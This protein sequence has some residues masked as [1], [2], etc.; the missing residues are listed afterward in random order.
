MKTTESGIPYTLQ[1]WV[2]ASTKDL[3]GML[4]ATNAV[5]S[6]GTSAR[7]AATATGARILSEDK[8]YI[9]RMTVPAPSLGAST[10]GAPDRAGAV[11]SEAAPVAELDEID[12]EDARDQIAASYAADPVLPLCARCGESV[13]VLEQWVDGIEKIWHERCYGELPASLRR[14]PQ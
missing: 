10:A 9:H 12:T 11:I 1:V 3:D 7:V 8:R 6:I 2:P 5:K 13:P 14:M 4:V